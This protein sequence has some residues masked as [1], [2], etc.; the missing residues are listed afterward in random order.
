VQ[1]EGV[2][3]LDLH[4][5]ADVV[6]AYYDVAKAMEARE[7]TRNEAEEKALHRVKQAEAES[8]RILAQANAAYTEKISEAAGQRDRFLARSQARGGQATLSDF[9]IFWEAVGKSLAGRDMVLIDADKIHGQRSLMLFEPDM[10]RAPP[11]I[12]PP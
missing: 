6:S 5:P 7:Q 8:M 9:R 3:I 2:A 11:V 1:I 10:F 12:L 4:P